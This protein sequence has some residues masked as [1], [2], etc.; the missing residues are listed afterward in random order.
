[1]TS[2]ARSDFAGPGGATLGMQWAGLTEV[3]GCEFDQDAVDTARANGMTRWMV[4]VT[5]LECR[6]YAWP[7]IDVYQ[8][9]PPCQSWSMGGKGEGRAHMEH[10]IAAL[11]KVAAGML[12][13]DAVAAVADKAL[14]VR[15]VLTLEPMNVIRDHRPR[16]IW[17]EQVPPVLPVWQAYAEILRSWGYSVW[18]GNLHSEQ[19][20]VPQTRKRAI[21]MAR[22]A[23][24]TAEFGEVAPPAATH[25]RYYSHNP[26]KLD[27]DVLPWV[28]IA[29]ALGVAASMRSN[30]GT[31]GDPAA[32]GER[33]AAEP[34]PTVTG[35]VGRNKWLLQG[36]QKPDG[37]NYQQRPEGSPAQTVTGEAQSYKWV[38]GDVRT[39]K[40]TLRNENQPTATLTSSIDNG[41]TRW[42]G[43]DA[44]DQ[45]VSVSVS[46]AAI[47]QSFPPGFVF[48][49][50]KS[51]QYR[52]VGDAVPPLMAE[53]ITRALLGLDASA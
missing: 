53:A 8:A 52:Q 44:E 45:P 19:F 14:D 35:K 51:A 31:G 1:V 18:V 49:G 32:R 11:A 25:S 16:F 50:N 40:G 22:D 34:A 27:N 24:A 23:E 9:S 28:P 47:L 43:S 29:Q 21:L 39:S 15:T 13:E 33:D 46:E 42:T 37:V 2:F 38:L 26:A 12:P 17:F 41:N 10:I 5:S 4:D 6:E 48:S 3:V 36:N 20:G 30:Y 7:R